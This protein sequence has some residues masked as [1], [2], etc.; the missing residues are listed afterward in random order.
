MI[1][2]KGVSTNYGTLAVSGTL[3]IL[4]T[5]YLSVF[6]NSQKDETFTIQSESGTRWILE[7]DQMV[8]SSIFVLR[9]LLKIWARAICIASKRTTTHNMRSCCSC[10]IFIFLCFIGTVAFCR[11]GLI[12]FHNAFFAP[13]NFIWPHASIRHHAKRLKDTKRILRLLITHLTRMSIR[14]FLQPIF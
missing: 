10:S 4:E 11:H 14:I 12:P 5:Q 1:E 9:K 6:V 8:F 3:M 13:K 2:G 7:F